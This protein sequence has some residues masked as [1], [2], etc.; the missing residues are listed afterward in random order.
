[1]S[2]FFGCWETHPSSGFLRLLRQEASSSVL[3][4]WDRK[5]KLPR[6]SSKPRV[7]AGEEH[8][9]RERSFWG[10]ARDNAHCRCQGE[11]GGQTPGCHRGGVCARV[12]VCGLP[13]EWS[14]GAT[15]C[16]PGL[17]APSQRWAGCEA[18][19]GA[20]ISG[21]SAGGPEL[22]TGHRSSPARLQ[23][24]WAK[25]GLQQAEES[26]WARPG[27]NVAQILRSPET[28]KG[29]AAE[30]E[31]QAQRKRTKVTMAPTVGRWTFI[32][33][34]TILTRAPES[35]LQISVGEFPFW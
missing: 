24:A 20:L 4:S 17:V 7:S 6:T 34:R 25:A 10:R 33:A 32:Q 11:R 12:C 27:R 31:E 30:C 22:R 35:L 18:A 9:N 13:S 14:P 21:P 1:M 3:R 8:L 28:K 26:A 29:R 15:G 5:S 2:L 23:K 19:S 16:V